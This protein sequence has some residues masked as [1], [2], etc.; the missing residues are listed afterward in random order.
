MLHA[1]CDIFANVLRNGVTAEVPVT[2]R[3]TWTVCPLIETQ[4]LV[5]H[6]TYIGDS[7]G[8]RIVN[9]QGIVPFAL[10][11]ACALIARLPHPPTM[12]R[13]ARWTPWLTI[14]CF[15]FPASR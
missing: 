1:F 10:R 13:R 3:S 9:V 7:S 6:R 12:N 5:V 11:L 14:L 4:T 2:A 8:V 15:Q